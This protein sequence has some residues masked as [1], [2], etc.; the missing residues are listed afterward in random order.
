MKQI[1]VSCNKDCG[2]GCPLLAHIEN[3][4][5]KKITDNPGINPYMRGCSRGYRM[6]LVVY[7]RE[8]LKKP[9]LQTGERG[10]NNFREIEWPEAFRIISLKLA[11]L[12]M[13]Y[14]PSTI[15][16]LGGSGACRGALHNTSI[17]TRRFLKF[18]G[19]FTDT[20]G[21]YSAAASDFINPYVFGTRFIGLDPAA[22]QFSQLIIL[23][24]ANISDTRFGCEMEARLLEQ[25]KKGVPIIVIDPRKT[26][27]VK[28]LGTQWIPVFP[29]TDTAFMA[30][31]LYILITEGL[32][33]QEF[34]HRYSTGFN[35]LESYILGREDGTPKTPGWAEK[36][37]GTDS[38]TIAE[39]ARQYGR[40]GRAA[41]IPGLSIQR[42]LGGEETARMAVVLQ[43]ATGN[44]GLPG[45]S[46]G[47]NIWNRLKQPV[48]G[49]MVIPDGGDLRN[50]PV[51]RWA[52][53][54]LDG[55]NGIK[56]IYNVGG[57][58]ISQGS[59]VKKNIKAFE[60]VAFSICHD[61]FMTPTA[62]YCHVI[63]PVTTF[64]E[65]EDIIFPENNCLFYSR[66][67]IAPLHESKNDY[68]IFCELAERLGFVTDFSE[69]RTPSQWLDAFLEVSE[70]P[71][72]A[73]F[74]ETGI[75]VSE[76]GLRVGLSDF[77]TDPEKHHLNTPSGK[78]E[79]SSAGYEKTGFPAIPVYRHYSGSL[80]YP[81]RMVTP[82]ARYRVNSQNYNIPWYRKLEEQ[83]VW[84][85]PLD[86][87]KRNI[88]DGDMVLIEN[89]IGKMRIK[90]F[91]IEDI[92]PGVVSVLQG[93]WPRLD[94][95]MIDTAGCANILT[96]TVP[97]EPSQGAR[98]HSIFVEVRR[99]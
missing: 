70:V 71:D 17:L 40:A 38:E 23:W 19:G 59:D 29:G 72:P 14:G 49:K 54:V 43:L 96:S 48:C 26:S 45:G 37:C 95:D 39:F 12:K 1:P 31:V 9:L 76:N 2:A 30:A 57:N 10:S 18:F 90:A 94:K 84:I 36:I 4:I 41:L 6:P 22:L 25:K 79:I 8:R 5:L 62:R 42:T 44:T 66:Q 74:K 89:E 85:H 65:R 93:A 92:M 98:T 63:L 15:L 16:F 83:A 46:S 50:I 87:H 86:A 32:A 97:T 81:L 53:A 88:K 56:A 55:Y 28:R 80:H 13:L 21:T 77:I 82:H 27:T 24:G 75:Y 51:Y 34:I 7:S 99:A 78:V 73:R 67:A 3:D 68:D 91:V 11:E 60:K 33:K 35:T 69:G 47:G 58:Y 61:Y 20:T 64:L 52:D